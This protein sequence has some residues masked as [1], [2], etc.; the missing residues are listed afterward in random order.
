[1]VSGF[2]KLPYEDTPKYLYLTTL[3][4][5]NNHGDLLKVFRICK[6]LDALPRVYFFRMHP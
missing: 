1:M 2:E 5:N 3:K 4:T 6:T